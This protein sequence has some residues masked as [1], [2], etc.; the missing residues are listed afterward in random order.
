M[1]IADFTDP[2]EIAFHRWQHPG[3]SAAHRFGDEGGDGVG[4]Q[5]LDFGLKLVGGTKAIFFFAFTVP[6]VTI[7]I[8]RRDVAGLD[9]DRLERLTPER[10]A[11]DGQRPQGIAVV[12]LATGDKAGARRLSD[13]QKILARHFQRRLDS[14]GTAGHEIDPIDPVRRLADEMVSQVLGRLRGEKPGVGEG[15]VFGLILNR[16]NNVGVGMPQTTDGGAARSIQ[17]PFA[18]G[19]DNIDAVAFDRARQLIADHAREDMRAA[20]IV[21]GTHGWG[22]FITANKIIIVTLQTADD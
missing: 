4:A 15:Q 20:R 6:A 8:T 22:P 10:I 7:G 5:T 1:T 18:V 17:V 16:P 13:F 19:V 3:G 21:G 14:L 11:A 2:F 12:A 9:Q